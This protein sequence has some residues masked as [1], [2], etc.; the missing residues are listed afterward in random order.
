MRSRDTVIS[1]VSLCPDE[2]PF[3]VWHWQSW[4]HNSANLWLCNC[5]FYKVWVHFNH[6]WFWW[7]QQL[8]ELT[9]CFNASMPC[10]CS[11]FYTHCRSSAIIVLILDHQQCPDTLCNPMIHYTTPWYTMQPQDTQSLGL[12]LLVHCIYIVPSL[13]FLLP[14]Q[15][16][17]RLQ[18]YI[19]RI[20]SDYFHIHIHTFL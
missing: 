17:C 9:Y 14:A 16:T 12:K 10:I 6:Q 8:S 11:C 19:P 7:V 5:H 13:T 15:A 4:P 20:S 18:S 1:S 3:Y 2:C